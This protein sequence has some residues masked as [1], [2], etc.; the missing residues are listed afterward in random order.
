MTTVS[1]LQVKLINAKAILTQISELKGH[2]D[3]KSASEVALLVS[4]AEAKIS[5][6]KKIGAEIEKLKSDPAF[7]NPEEVV[8]CQKMVNG[9]A[10]LKLFLKNSYF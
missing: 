1:Q 4:Q 9:A 8:L 5:K 7:L 6:S 2:R 10:Q 3:F